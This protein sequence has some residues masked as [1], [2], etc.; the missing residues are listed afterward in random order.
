MSTW[1]TLQKPKMLQAVAH[2]RRQMMYRIRCQRALRRQVHRNWLRACSRRHYRR[3]GHRRHRRRGR[4]HRRDPLLQKQ[5][6]RL[7]LPAAR[8][9]VHVSRQR[10]RRSQDCRHQLL[11]QTSQMISSAAD[12]GS[13]MRHLT[14]GQTTSSFSRGEKRKACMV[15]GKHFACITRRTRLLDALVLKLAEP[16]QKMIKLACF[17]S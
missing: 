4:G 10:S 2:R 3:R 7:A 6:N 12:P 15:D 8:P 17:V 11:L 14:R 16:R 1:Q 9:A 13:T 5:G